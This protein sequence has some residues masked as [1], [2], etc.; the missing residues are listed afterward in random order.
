MG[1]GAPQ[2]DAIAWTAPPAWD[3]C[4]PTGTSQRCRREQM[5]SETGSWGDAAYR[6][7]PDAPGASRH[8]AHLSGPTTADPITV[9]CSTAHGQATRRAPIGGHRRRRAPRHRSPAVPRSRQA[10]A[11]SGN[12]LGPVPI[13]T[14]GRRERVGFAASRSELCCWSISGRANRVIGARARD[15][16]ATV[17]V[18]A[19]VSNPATRWCST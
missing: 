1:R 14:R 17:R 12:P 6:P 2:R 8:V 9:G 4:Q 19:S 13:P 15:G 10:L 11:R 18:C 5:T 16:S 3:A 7:W